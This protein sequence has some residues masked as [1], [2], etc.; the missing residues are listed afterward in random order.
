MQITLRASACVVRAKWRYL[1]FDR[2]PGRIESRNRYWNSVVARFL[3]HRSFPSYI[4]SRHLVGSCLNFIFPNFFKTNFIKSC[5]VENNRSIVIERRFKL[6]IWKILCVSRIVQQLS[7]T[8]I[9]IDAFRKVFRGVLSTNRR[10]VLER[11]WRSTIAPRPSA[12]SSRRTGVYLVKV[13]VSRWQALFDGR[14]RR[15]TEARVGRRR[16]TGN[17]VT[18]RRVIEPVCHWFKRSRCSFL[19][20]WPENRDPSLVHQI[21]CYF[22]HRSLAEEMENLLSAAR[23]RRNIRFSLKFRVFFSRSNDI[24]SRWSSEFEKP[25]EQPVWNPF[26]GIGS[27]ETAWSCRT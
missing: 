1:N 5:P 19:A 3:A 4:K 15:Q 25:I 23:L 17:G 20:L 21:S 6:F 13:R 12:R 18:N 10:G 22:A 9:E 26:V 7:R 2:N 27:Q 16:I 8:N 24:S 11:F 14:E